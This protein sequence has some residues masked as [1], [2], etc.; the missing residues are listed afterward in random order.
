MGAAGSRATARVLTP[1]A[2]VL[3]WAWDEARLSYSFIRNDVWTTVIPATAFVVAAARHSGVDGAALLTAFGKGALYFWLFI[4]GFTLTNQLFGIEEDRV[5][6]P[7]RPLVAGQCSHRG[8]RVRAALVLVAFP[9]VGWWL[10]V[11]PWA[12]LWE[13]S[14][15][16]STVARWERHWL[17]KNL[18]IGVGVLSQLAAAWQM[19]APIGP[20]AWR[21][22]GTLAV[23][24]LV[25]IP[26]QDL[27]DIDGD[28]VNGRTTFPVAFGQPATRYYLAVGFGCLPVATH[29]LLFGSGTPPVAPL[30][31]AALAVLSWW[32]AVRVLTRRSPREDHRTQRRFEQWY[33][34]A[35]ASAILV[36]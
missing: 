17:W 12:L 8:A 28:V 13:G 15:L 11:L 6:K 24:V 22:I 25:L 27:R 18:S 16:L 10:G 14:Y 35:L 3:R 19:V 5:N 34:I 4:Y 2:S 23:V 29:L 26:L 30:V 21:W 36:L 9:L 31:D 33:T 20:L 32:I 7:Y 1:L